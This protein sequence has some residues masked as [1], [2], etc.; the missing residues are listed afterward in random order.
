[1]RALRGDQ[2]RK[3]SGIARHTGP[4]RLRHQRQVRQPLACSTGPRYHRWMRELAVG[5][6]N[7]CREHSRLHSVQDTPVQPRR[8]AMAARLTDHI[9]P[10][11]AWVLCP[12][13]GGQ[14]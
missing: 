8:P 7:F 3:T 6:D 4:R 12:V 1:V 11:R 14:G 2:Q 9:W 10:I 5:L 13:V